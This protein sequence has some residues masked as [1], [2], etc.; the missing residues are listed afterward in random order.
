M[1][2]AGK[3]D[4]S[5]AFAILRQVAEA[6]DE[7]EDRFRLGTMAYLLTDFGEAQAQL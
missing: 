4:F 6:S 3:G 2:L 7:P 1:Q 5:G